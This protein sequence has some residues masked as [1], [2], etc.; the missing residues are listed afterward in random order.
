MGCVELGISVAVKFHEEM[1]SGNGKFGIYC[2]PNLVCYGSII[3]GLF[4]DGLMEKA[5]E[6]FLEMK[7]RCICPDVAVYSPPMHGLCSMDEWEEAK[8]MLCQS[9][10]MKESSELFELMA[11]RRIEPDGF[12]YSTLID[13]YCLSGMIGDG[14]ELCVYGRQGLKY[15]KLFVEMQLHDLEPNLTKYN[16]CLDVLCKNNCVSE[17]VGLVSQFRKLNRR[18]GMLTTT[19]SL[20][21]CDIKYVLN[22]LPTTVSFCVQVSQIWISMGWNK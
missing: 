14:R 18:K 16:V 12:T 11:Q 2:K 15:S 9:W 6:L 17:A 20:K 1:L 10:K 4:K 21:I 3:D 22:I 19:V 13:G 8:D 5:K 7:G